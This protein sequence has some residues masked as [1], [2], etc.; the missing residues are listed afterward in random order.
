MNSKAESLTV[1]RLF[2][3]NVT[4][5]GAVALAGGTFPPC[6]Y[7]EALFAGK[8]NVGK[9]TLINAVTGQAKL[10]RASSTPGCTSQINFFNA[11]DRLTLTDVPGY[12]YAKASKTSRREWERLLE[13]YFTNRKD[14]VALAFILLDSRRGVSEPDAELSELFAAERVEWRFVLTKADKA[15]EDEIRAS[16]EQAERTAAFLGNPHAAMRTGA[17]R[18]EGVAELRALLASLIGS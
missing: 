8:S 2:S 11:S 5:A 3:G 1:R 9:S 14:R 13:Y 7:P 4:F 10:A 15:G 18:G 12:G 16:A 17:A 6:P